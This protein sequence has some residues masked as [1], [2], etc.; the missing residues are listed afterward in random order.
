MRFIPYSRWLLVFCLGWCHLAFAADDL[1]SVRHPDLSQLE[2]VVREAILAAQQFVAEAEQGGEQRSLGMSF[3]ELGMA[4]HAHEL[5]LGAEDSYRNAEALVPDDARWPYL[6]GTLLQESGRF[7]ES[8]EAFQRSLE[9]NPQYLPADIRLGMVL[10]DAQRFEDAEAVYLQALRNAPDNPAVLDA[11]GRLALQRGDHDRAVGYLTQALEVQPD[12]NRLYHPLGMAHRGLGETDKAR[13]YLAKAGSTQP[14]FADPVMTDM[15]GRS[16]SYARFLSAGMSA[17]KE[18]KYGISAAYFERALE[19]APDNANVRISYARALEAL[20]EE[21]AAMKQLDKIIEDHP[22]FAAAYF[23]KGAMLEQA[24]DELH[25]H[26]LYE[27]ALVANPDHF[28]AR[29]LLANG[30]MRAGRFQDAATQYESVLETQPENVQVKFRRALAL[31]QSG[32]CEQSVDEILALIRDFP[33]DVD[34]LEA[35]IRSVAGCSAA[36]ETDKENALNAGRNLAIRYPEIRFVA[37]AA[38]IEAASG[39]FEAAQ[40]FQ[41]QAI[42]LALRDGDQAQAE[43]LRKQMVGYERNELDNAAW[44]ADHP[45]LKPPRVRPQDRF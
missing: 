11:L 44:P 16:Q 28:E 20:G 31:G 24:G 13:E 38:L 10:M 26:S 23:D 41:A 7:E 30:H 45:F 14:F 4:Y 37:L 27:K 19:L 18:R 35:Y 21:D 29:I 32:A 39:D 12:A 36:S 15:L 22:D 1:I 40:S 3:G 8:I 5:P 25:A 43:M 2:G 33:T 17:A 9:D 6:L 42:F 34:L